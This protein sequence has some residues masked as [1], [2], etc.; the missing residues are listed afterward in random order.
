MGYDES[1]LTTLGHLKELA[2]KVKKDYVTKA[3]LEEA[4]ETGGGGE[5]GGTS[6]HRELTN[7]DAA[8]QHPISSITHLEGELSRRL[9]E[10]S[11]LSVVE[12]IKIMEE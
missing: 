5:A 8:E 10:D 12:I 1:K 2:Q 9:T 7:R 3:E 6:D 4:L 11:A